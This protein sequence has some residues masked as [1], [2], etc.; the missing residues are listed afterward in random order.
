MKIF[1][2]LFNNHLKFIFT[3]RELKVMCL[4]TIANYY[5]EGYG[6]IVGNEIWETL[7]DDS[8]DDSELYY[9]Y[10]RLKNMIKDIAKRNHMNFL[11][12]HH[13]YSKCIKTGMI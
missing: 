1:S 13:I 5:E 11:M 6:C 9:Q 12:K 10:L 2:T 4:S 8:Y 7:F 3:S